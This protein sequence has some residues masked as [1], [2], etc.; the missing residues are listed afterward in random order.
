MTVEIEHKGERGGM[1]KIAYKSL[2]QLDE[3]VR[4]L[5]LSTEVD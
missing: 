3:L 1:V 4:R 2:E 5:S